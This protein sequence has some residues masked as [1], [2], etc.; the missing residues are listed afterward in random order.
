MLTINNR[1]VIIGYLFAVGLS[2]AQQEAPIQTTSAQQQF[3]LSQ[4]PTPA[5]LQQTLSAIQGQ[6]TA[7]TSGV[8]NVAPLPAAVTGAQ[9]TIPTSSIPSNTV[10]PASPIEQPVPGAPAQPAGT[11]SQSTTVQPMPILSSTPITSS[12]VQPISTITPA[13]ITPP[14]SRDEMRPIIING[15]T[16]IGQPATTGVITGT[17]AGTMPSLATA[18]SQTVPVPT[19]S[20]SSAGVS[21]N[22]QPSTMPTSAM[23]TS[24]M[25]TPTITTPV[26]PGMPT[27]D[28][29]SAG[30][31]QQLSVTSIQPA[32]PF[33]PKPMVTEI[34]LQEVEPEPEIVGIDTMN[35]EEAQGNWL[36]KRIWWER[37][38]ERYEKIQALV[39]QVWEYRMQYFLKRSELDRST[40]D[41]FYVSVGLSQ[42]ELQEV[43]AE[44]AS[45]LDAERQQEGTLDQQERALSQELQTERESLQ[46]L[47]TVVDN[48]MELDH[49]ID[50]ALNR[51]LEQANKT[52]DYERESWTSFKQISQELSDAKARDLYYKMDMYM[53]NIKDIQRY[54]Q[55]DFAHYFQETTNKLSAEVERVKNVVQ[56]LKEKGVDLKKQSH[57]WLNGG[58]PEVVQPAQ[59]E[60]EDD[61]EPVVKKSGILHTIYQSLLFLKDMLVYPFY[62]I[63]NTL[64]GKSSTVATVTV[65]QNQVDI[66]PNNS[67]EYDQQ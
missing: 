6:A 63:Y 46:E 29:P 48:I 27:V 40:L 28:F 7:T 21:S 22:V 26:M 66:E 9:T 64:F 61:E 23:P 12:S 32:T 58:A 33:E 42:G 10:A 36:F 65:E 59:T 11:I 35:L 13:V 15:D 4:Q 49:A 45:K 51:L 54:L 24:S 31:A 3:Q 62:A 55:Q 57:Q 41:P 16:I 8:S 38:L 2:N 39:S 60:D 52:R 19:M 34:E 14:L 47:K 37:A 50:D 18:V 56:S 53:R 20:P 17:P 1:K 67:Q 5:E 44:I 25:T 43:I 30:Q